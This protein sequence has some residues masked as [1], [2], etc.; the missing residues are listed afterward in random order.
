MRNKSLLLA[1]QIDGVVT[2]TL[3]RPDQYNALSEELLAELQHNLDVIAQDDE[4]Y[5]VV[6][7]AAG[8]A[9][10]AGH[11][12]K[13]MRSRPDQ[14]YYEEL[15]TRCGRVMQSIVNLPVPVI[16]QVHGMATAAGCQLVASCD[17]AIAA[18]TA[19]FA[20]SGINVGLFC[21]TPAVA[22]TRNMPAKKAFEMLMTGRFI[23]ANEAM[24][25]GLVNQVVTS[26][27]LDAAVA[28]LVHT[29]CAKSP[30]AVRAGKDMFYR[31]LGMGLAD[32]YEYAGAAMACN[33]MADDAGEG[34]DAFME[35]RAPVWRGS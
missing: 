8:K 31:Q 5:C 25:Y 28:S 1:D 10:C 17:L 9:F 6:I 7:A 32:A 13:Q 4:V 14:A 26:A 29:I 27:Q 16:A 3:N 18:D 12:L 34:I 30:V 19:R 24:S 33:M 11:D 21:A 23:S 35:K 2:L 20:V 15:F 22:L